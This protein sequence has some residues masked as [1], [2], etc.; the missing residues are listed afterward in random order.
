[1]TLKLERRKRKESK[2]G[3]DGSNTIIKNGANLH[4]ENCHLSVIPPTRGSS[5]WE[6]TEEFPNIC[7]QF[8]DD[9]LPQWSP[10]ACVSS[11]ENGYLGVVSQD[12]QVRHK[13]KRRP[14]SVLAFHPAL[15]SLASYPNT[16]LYKSLISLFYSQS[17]LIVSLKCYPQ[18]KSHI[19][20]YIF[21]SPRKDITFVMTLEKLKC[22]QFCISVLYF[23]LKN[24]IMSSEC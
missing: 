21:I 16:A 11:W 23:T 2:K 17:Q 20:S 8:R 15:E 7:R 1:M 18:L 24:S 22:I 19:Q 10:P 13:S 5:V 14:R 6:G 3:Y 9:L 4:Q 12:S